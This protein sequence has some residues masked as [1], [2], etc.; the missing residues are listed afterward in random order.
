MAADRKMD[1]A[2]RDSVLAA[3]LA[4]YPGAFIGAIDAAGL[5]TTLPEEL[6]AAGLRPIEGP[7]SA[8][9]LV[10]GEDHR[11][12]VDTW[13]RLIAEGVANNLVRPIAAPDRQVRLHLIDMTHR[14][15]VHVCVLSGMEDHRAG[16]SLPSDQ[17]R[18]RLVTMYKDPTAVITEAGPEVVPLLGWSAGVRWTWFIPRTTTG[19]S[20][21]GWSC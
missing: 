20:P 12:A 16:L 6:A 21:A 13:H 9:G 2:G 4:Q 18:P 10:I 8:L 17:V 14:L 19:R 3:T 15:G 5:F 1:P 7:S 11:I